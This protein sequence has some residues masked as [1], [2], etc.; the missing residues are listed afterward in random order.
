MDYSSKA[1]SFNVRGFLP[2]RGTIS[3]YSCTVCVRTPWYTQPYTVV[4]NLYSVH[5]IHDTWVEVP[6]IPSSKFKDSRLS[7]YYSYR[8][9]L[10]TAVPGTSTVGTVIS[11]PIRMCLCIDTKFSMCC[12]RVHSC[13]PGTEGTR[14]PYIST[15]FSRLNQDTCLPQDVCKHR[16][17]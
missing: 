1:K 5:S 4:K 13:I 12:T 8:R 9:Y 15:K 2:P 16:I 3:R 14:V 6:S 17:L 7:L 11:I 10:G